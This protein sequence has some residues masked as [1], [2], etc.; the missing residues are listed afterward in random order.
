MVNF[1]CWISVTSQAFSS[2]LGLVRSLD[3]CLHIHIHLFSS[4][5]SFPRLGIAIQCT[6]LFNW[7]GICCI[8]FHSPLSGTENVSRRVVQ[9]HSSNHAPPI[10]RAPYSL[11]TVD[12]LTN[13]RSDWR[14]KDS[15]LRQTCDRCILSI[16][17]CPPCVG[18]RR[19][20]PA[21]DTLTRYNIIDSE[22]LNRTEYFLHSSGKELI[23]TLSTPNL[24]LISLH[25]LHHSIL[26]GDC[27]LSRYIPELPPPPQQDKFP[28]KVKTHAQGIYRALQGFPGATNSGDTSTRGKQP[29]YGWCLTD[30]NVKICLTMRVD[31]KNNE[32]RME[33]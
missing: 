27:Y 19:T 8:A 13:R 32:I 3:R 18:Q 16:E 12:D 10:E 31:R 5:F 22:F 6:H 23:E 24:L 14:R 7:H 33:S 2:Q 9:Q 25:S 20:P 29:D 28:D 15:R 17:P 4:C 30:V 21:R 26:L 11:S 1:D